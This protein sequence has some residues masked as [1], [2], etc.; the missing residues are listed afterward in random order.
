MADEKPRGGG[1]LIRGTVESYPY[2]MNAV[3]NATVD[4]IIGS[5]GEGP[6][7]IGAFCQRTGEAAGDC[8][9]TFAELVDLGVL[10]CPVNDGGCKLYQLIPEFFS[11][12]RR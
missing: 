4:K 9:D 10:R 11:P 1:G 3:Q 6:F 8:F 2:G 5:I 7:Q 12:K